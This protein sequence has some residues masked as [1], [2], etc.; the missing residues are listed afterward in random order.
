MSALVPPRTLSTFS[1]IFVLWVLDILDRG[2][3]GTSHFRYTSDVTMFVV[4]WT[5]KDEIKTG[6][7]RIFACFRVMS[8]LPGPVRAYEARI[9][10]LESRPYESTGESRTVERHSS[11]GKE[12]PPYPQH[13]KVGIMEGDILLVIPV[14]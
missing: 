12:H 11:T 8:A 2:W 14:R 1:S 13:Q 4:W 5:G 9:P 3:L 6:K 10:P 7:A